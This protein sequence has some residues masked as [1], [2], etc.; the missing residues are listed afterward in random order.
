MLGF[1]LFRARRRRDR[2][3]RRQAF[4]MLLQAFTAK[5]LRPNRFVK[6]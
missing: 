2:L 4:G 1:V 6:A 5:K 3:R